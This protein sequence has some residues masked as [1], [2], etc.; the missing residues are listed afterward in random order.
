MNIP[1]EL[2]PIMA[3]MAAGIPVGKIHAGQ[4]CPELPNMRM[5]VL[6]DDRKGDG[7]EAFDST[8]LFCEI[9]HVTFAVPLALKEGA[10]SVAVVAGH[11]KRA[12][13]IQTPSETLAR[14]VM[15]VFGHQRLM[16]NYAIIG[17]GET[18]ADVRELVKD[19]EQVRE[20]KLN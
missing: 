11:G 8:K 7:P 13:L 3:A 1:A 6:L 4:A 19:I 2:A 9:D 10:A 20:T 18:P 5:I 17:V 12:L 14:W 16:H 15:Q